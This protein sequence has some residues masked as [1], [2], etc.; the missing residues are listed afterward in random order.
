[1]FSL[2]GWPPQIHTGFHVSRATQVS[3]R[4]FQDF[5]YRAVTFYG[6]SFQMIL[7]SLLGLYTRS[8]NPA[9][10]R[11]DGLGCSRFA[12]HYSGN[13]IFFLLSGYLDVSVRRLLLSY[14]ICKQLGYEMTGYDSSRVSPFGN[15]RIK[16]CRT[17]P[18]LI[19]AD[20]VLHRLPA[21][22]H[23]PCA[24]SILNVSP[25]LCR[26]VRGTHPLVEMN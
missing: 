13:R 3:G 21:P 2:A 20:H 15:L 10:P 24:L 23:S 4:T 18:K 26:L 8:Y 25:Q 6:S 7:L 22:R 17:Y 12:R 5:T 14:L 11:T 1:M 16:G 19:A 9:D